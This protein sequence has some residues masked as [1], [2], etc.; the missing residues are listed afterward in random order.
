MVSEVRVRII[1][2]TK[3]EEE[4]IET[5]KYNSNY[6]LVYSDDKTTIYELIDKDRGRAKN[7]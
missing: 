3:S 2:D 7:G 1:L 4:A 5:M 6:K